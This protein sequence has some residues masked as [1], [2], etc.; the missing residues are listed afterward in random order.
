MSSISRIIYYGLIFSFII[1]TIWTGQ[2]IM[3]AKAGAY[4]TWLSFTNSGFEA[5]DNVGWLDYTQTGANPET[6]CTDCI[7]SSSTPG[8]CINSGG[9]GAWLGGLADQTDRIWQGTFTIPDA[10][11]VSL[12]YAFYL[13]GND[14]DGGDYLEVNAY[15][16]GVGTPEEQMKYE[17]LNYQMNRFELGTLDL[18]YMAGKSVDIEFKQVNDDDLNY[19]SAFID[20]VGILV[21]YNDTGKPTGSIRINNNVPR[22]KSRAVALKMSATD[23]ISGVR[24]MRF[25]NNNKIWSGW[26]DYASSKSWDLSDTTFGGNSANGTKRVYVQFRDWSGVNSNVYSDTIVFDNTGPSGTI[27]INKKAKSTRKKSVILYLRAT[28]LSGVSKMRFSNNGTRWSTWINYAAK[29]TK[30]D[31]TKNTYGGSKKKGKKYV[32][33]QYKDVLGNISAKK[34]DSITYR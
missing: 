3:K 8:M 9:W 7:V 23:T 19:G 4:L 16:H 28:D 32:W 24:Y 17:L 12:Y 13:D 27:N 2:G 25:S 21:T 29:K 30:W 1:S 15:E 33:V 18:S 14:T 22:T 6:A 26:Y 11:N 10:F 20:D 31:I 5:G 34:R